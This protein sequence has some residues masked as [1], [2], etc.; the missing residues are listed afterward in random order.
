MSQKTTLYYQSGNSD[1]IYQVEIISAADNT[2]WLVNFAYGRRGSTLKADTKTH[3]PVGRAEAERIYEQL[4]KSKKAKG[5]SE[6]ADG[7][8]YLATL[9]QNR[10]TDINLQLLNAI[11][12]QQ[13]DVLIKDNGIGAQEK[14]DGI[15]MAVSVSD[16][17]EIQAINRRGLRCGLS[18]TVAS[19]LRPINGQTGGYVIDG[20]AIGDRLF[21]FD[22]LVINGQDVRSKGYA[23]RYELLAKLLAKIDGDGQV[24]KLAPLVL[25]EQAKKE[26]YLHLKEKNKE[27]IV[28]KNLD[29]EYCAGRPN[30]GGDL[31]KFKFQAEAT[32]Q[33]VGSRSGKRSVRLQVRTSSGEMVDVGN[34]TIP[35]NKAIPGIG[36]LVEIRYLYFFNGGSL[37]QP[38]YKGIRE[39]KTEADLYSSL[40]VK[41]AV[42]A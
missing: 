29:A 16:C 22:V 39:D 28:F 11:E 20:E 32:C 38:F 18:Q 19:A 35:P 33:V 36:D 31:L 24:L 34:C 10:M 9:N 2:G 1:K 12:E 21:A 5:Y 14:Y 17:G 37:Y 7:T 27:G 25:G 15:R 8:P 26:F 6:G 4:V 13:L 3:H 40:K 42:P 41:A 30:S 23:E